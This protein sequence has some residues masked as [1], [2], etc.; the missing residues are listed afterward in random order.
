LSQSSVG[1]SSVVLGDVARLSNLPSAMR[2][3][4]QSLAIYE[5]PAG[6][7]R[8]TLSA[9]F[10]VERASNLLPALRPWLDPNANGVV[11][12]TLTKR[13][14]DE[15]TQSACMVAKTSLAVGDIATRSNFTAAACPPEGP[16]ARAFRYSAATGSAYAVRSITAGE[17]V[18]S[19]PSGDL[20]AVR[21]GQ[22]LFI[23]A[24]AGPVRV[25][26][27]VVAVQPAAMGRALFVKAADGKVF[28]VPGVR[29]SP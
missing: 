25:Q 22:S 20:A 18:L 10:I 5:I 14:D 24:R 12:V 8:I 13:H 6:R 17:Q 19:V 27:E 16:S 11:E 2:R 26:R 1:H 7:R 15:T 4:A 3:R 21:P 28:S 9:K 23:T 29:T